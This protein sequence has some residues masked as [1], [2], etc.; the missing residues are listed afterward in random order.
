MIGAT[1]D[2]ASFPFSTTRSTPARYFTGGVDMVGWG[3]VVLGVW[4]MISPAVI[5]STGVASWSAWIAAVL[6]AIAGARLARHHRTWQALLAGIA[7]ACTLVAGFIPRLQS[8]DQFIG[9][10][11]I[12]GALFFIAG[13]AA[14]FGHSETGR[15]AA[16]A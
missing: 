3:A 13:I 11:V 5:R 1:R 12:F 15:P 2:Y 8:G 4:L 9:R 10:S 7:A 6:G 14:A 16:S